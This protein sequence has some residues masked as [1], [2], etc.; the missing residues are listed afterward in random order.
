MNSG[1]LDIDVIE[2]A[3]WREAFKCVVSLIDAEGKMSGPRK[4]AGRR[5][6]PRMIIN[7]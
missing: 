7:R 3:G 6:K 2:S 5:S 4:N 1:E